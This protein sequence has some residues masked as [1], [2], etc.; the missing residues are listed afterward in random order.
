[1]RGA[2]REGMKVSTLNVRIQASDDNFAQFAPNA[3]QVSPL[4]GENECR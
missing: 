3:G 2:Y 4:V 1:M